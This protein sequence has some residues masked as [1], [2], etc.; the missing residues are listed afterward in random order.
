MP[1]NSFRLYLLSR[2]ANLEIGHRRERGKTRQKGSHI[3]TL[4]KSKSGEVRKWK[5]ERRGRVEE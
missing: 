2:Y 4:K 5:K 3:S 1:R